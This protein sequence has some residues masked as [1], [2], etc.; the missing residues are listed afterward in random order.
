MALVFFI[1]NQKSL[2]TTKNAPAKSYS[3]G[4]GAGF[5]VADVSAGVSDWASVAGA[6]G[7][8]T[9]AAAGLD[10]GFGGVGGL[11]GW[12]RGISRPFTA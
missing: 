10:F 11:A 6:G 8:S 5:S 9:T 7:G 3:S 1:C 12:R 2:Q 4:C